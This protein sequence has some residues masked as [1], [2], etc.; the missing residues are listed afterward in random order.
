[1]A[2]LHA[3]VPRGPYYSEFQLGGLESLQLGPAYRRLCRT[4]ESP[5]KIDRTTHADQLAVCGRIYSSRRRSGLTATALSIAQGATNTEITKTKSVNR[6]AFMLNGAV[7]TTH[8]TTTHLTTTRIVKYPPIFYVRATNRG[9]QGGCVCSLFWWSLV[10]GGFGWVCR[11][12]LS[13]SKS[14]VISTIDLLDMRCSSL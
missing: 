14:G 1:V 7:D 12:D 9:R 10:G 13:L 6:R 11:K 5:P 2:S 8:L 4:L 3:L